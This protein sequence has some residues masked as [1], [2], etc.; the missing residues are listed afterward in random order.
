MSVQL[1]DVLENFV[2]ESDSDN[3]NDHGDLN[4]MSVDTDSF[5]ED[6][7]EDFYTNDN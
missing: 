6:F 5:D 3:D 2:Y 4:E 1:V 7:D